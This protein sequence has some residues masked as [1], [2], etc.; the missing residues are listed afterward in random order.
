[1]FNNNKTAELLQVNWWLFY[2]TTYWWIRNILLTL[3]FFVFLEE[4]LLSIILLL[5]NEYKESIDERF[6]VM[7]KEWT[8]TDR[9]INDPETCLRQHSNSYLL[10]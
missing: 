7:G 5:I 3:V 10:H 6:A 2:F 1:M 9:C 8:K 4:E